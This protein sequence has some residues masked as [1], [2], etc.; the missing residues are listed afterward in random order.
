MGECCYQ[1]HQ[2]SKEKSA[3][4]PGPGV[5]RTKSTTG[6]QDGPFSGS[7]ALPLHLVPRKAHP[8]LCPNTQAGTETVV[9]SLPQLGAVQGGR[10]R[11]SWQTGGTW[12][13]SGQENVWAIVLTHR[14]PPWNLEK[15]PIH[16]GRESEAFWMLP[17]QETWPTPSW[18]AVHSSGHPSPSPSPYRRGRM[19][20]ETENL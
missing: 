3:G 11:Y 14:M 8:G 19:S 1:G 12:A 17:C 16:Q 7:T 18:K 15:A 6:S 4:S 9:M 10:E 2:D 5:V 20:A 13:T